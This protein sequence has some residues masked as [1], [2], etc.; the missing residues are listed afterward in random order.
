MNNNF[1]D[2]FLQIL[3][4]NGM[5]E[6]CTVETAEKFAAL[7]EL[8]KSE[9]KKYNLTA[10][11][12]DEQI[13]LLHFVDSLTAVK[14]L[15][16]SS[17]LDIG[18]GAGFPSLP[19]AIVRPDIKVF[20][21]DATAK[22][23]NFSNLAAKVLGLYNFKAINGRA[24]ELAAQTYEYRENFDTVTARAVA[25]LPILAELCAPFVRIGGKLVMLKSADVGD[26]LKGHIYAQKSLGIRFR[27]KHDLTISHGENVN[28]R[29]VVIF[30]KTTACGKKY[31]RQYAAI[32]NK[33]LF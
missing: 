5:N 26:E 20:A 31:P 8:L 28:S 19:I 15:G 4:E 14:Y 3:G 33:P 1:F 6:Y 17:L 32:K 7:A 10:I 23:T 24:E 12:E 30:D 27:S 29:S 22:K 13:I 18:S 11:T 16:G 25:S 2:L 9:N 21:L